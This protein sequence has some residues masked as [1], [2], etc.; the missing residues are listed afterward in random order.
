[1]SSKYFNPSYQWFNETQSFHVLHVSQLLE[2]LFECPYFQVLLLFDEQQLIV[3][4]NL[5]PQKENLFL[6]NY[7]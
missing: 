6:Y 2:D 5:E 1:M 4:I 3:F 7:E